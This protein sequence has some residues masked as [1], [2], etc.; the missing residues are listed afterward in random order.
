VSLKIGGYIQPVITD[1]TIDVP[2]GS[3]VAVY[4]KIGFSSVLPFLALI[5]R[6]RLPTPNLDKTTGF[7]V[8][9]G[10]RVDKISA[11]GNK[12]Y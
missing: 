8:V 2:S 9:G 4:E 5:N 1:L 3:K 12:C 6:F 7:V 10:R 11:R